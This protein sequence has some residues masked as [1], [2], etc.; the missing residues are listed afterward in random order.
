MEAIKK[1][2]IM[3]WRGLK[4]G[5]EFEYKSTIAIKITTMVGG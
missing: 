3:L 1:I 2:I 4:E 5:N